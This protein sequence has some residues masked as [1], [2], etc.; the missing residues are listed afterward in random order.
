V[1]DPTTITAEA[2]A[3]ISAISLIG[4]PLWIRWRERRK[5]MSE[6]ENVSWAGMN[7]AL[8]DE[9]DHLQARLDT[10]EDRSRQQMK[11]MEEDFESRTFNMRRRIAEL[12]TEVQALH[13]SLRSLGGVQ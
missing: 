10:A 5:N 7:K 3:V 12:E 2:T 6:A 13:L 4:I 11:Q 1:V 8:R 9:R